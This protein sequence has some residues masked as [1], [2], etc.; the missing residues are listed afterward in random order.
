[1]IRVRLVP[2]PGWPPHPVQLVLTDVVRRL[3]DWSHLVV[4]AL[5]P[6]VRVSPGPAQQ[7][8]SDVEAA[9]IS[10]QHV[11]QGEYVVF[12][13]VAGGDG[14]GD[15]DGNGGGDGGDNNAD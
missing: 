13:S 6:P 9:V 12:S 8:S 3:F 4:A 14:R 10:S 1:M 2:C 15:G 11:L 7:A 5:L